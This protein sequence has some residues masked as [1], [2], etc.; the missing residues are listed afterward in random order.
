MTAIS[1]D[2]R[3]RSRCGCI[4]APSPGVP[5]GVLSIMRAGWGGGGTKEVGIDGHK[6]REPGTRGTVFREDRDNRNFC[7]TADM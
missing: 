7:A 4:V 3:A 2:E 1:L 6:A 5:R